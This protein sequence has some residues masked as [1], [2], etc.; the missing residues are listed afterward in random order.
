MFHVIRK[1]HPDVD[2][3]KAEEIL[4]KMHAEVIS[5]LKDPANM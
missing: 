1:N 5:K 2:I 4:Q 3:A